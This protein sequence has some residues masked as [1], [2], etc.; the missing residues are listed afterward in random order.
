MIH[1]IQ[2][3][4]GGGKSLYSLMQIIEELR[5]GSRFVCTNLDIKLP[6][7]NEYMCSEFGEDKH[8]HAVGAAW[9]DRV[10]LLTEDESKSFWTCEGPNRDHQ[11]RTSEG[12]DFSK[13]L[14]HGVLYV[15]DECHIHFSAREWQKT[16]KDCMFYC[17]QHRKLGDDVMLVTQHPEQADKNFRRLAQD[18]TVLRNMGNETLIGFRFADRFRRATYLAEKKPKDN[19]A[20]QEKGWFKLDKQVASCYN[21]TAGVGILARADVKEKKGKGKHPAFALVYVAIF[22]AILW[23]APGLVREGFGAAMGHVLGAKK[24]IIGQTGVVPN[25][26]ETNQSE[27]ETGE[28]NRGS[29]VSGSRP[30][31]QVS[32]NGRTDVAKGLASS[33][34]APITIKRVKFVGLERTWYLSD[35][36]VFSI[37]DPRILRGGENYLV[38]KDGTYISR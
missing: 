6:E 28:A 15:I 34:V 32:G 29:D 25:E 17:S 1:F 8:A 11:E 35:G 13:R 14:G 10:R 21:T 18:F 38:L 19:Q 36:S 24:D 7:L 26:A 4:P 33:S 30:A 23:F 22:L 31:D 37:P 3:K 27:V 16:S 20:P 5:T 2:G 12:T 9:T